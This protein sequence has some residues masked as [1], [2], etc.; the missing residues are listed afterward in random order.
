MVNTKLYIRAKKILLE[1]FKDSEILCAMTIKNGF[2]F[3]IKPKNAKDYVLDAFFKVTHE[4]S[5]EEY[6]PVMNP[7]EFRNAMNNVIYSKNK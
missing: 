7:K 6:S 5:I 3:S 4:G 2:L 1:K